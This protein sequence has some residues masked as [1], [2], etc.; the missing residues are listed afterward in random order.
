MDAAGVTA[1]TFAGGGAAGEGGLVLDW[2]GRQSFIGYQMC[3]II[4]QH[5]LVS[6]ACN[7][8]AR[9][10]VRQGYDILLEGFP[11]G[12]QS[13]KI[14]D[15]IRK[16]DRRFR[17]RQQMQEYI[18]FGRVFGIR[19]AIYVHDVPPDQ[20][21]EFYSNPYNPDSVTP[22]SYRGISQVDPYWM[23]PMLSG[24]GA[25]NAAGQHFYDPEWWN[26]QGRMYHRSHLCIYRPNEVADVLKPMYSYGGVSVAQSIYERVYAAERTANEAP[27]LAMT[28]RTTVW[29]TDLAEAF[30]N[31]ERFRTNLEIWTQFRDNYGVKIN[32]L[33]DTMQQ[34]ETSLADLDAVIMGQYQLVAAIARVPATK[35]L[36]TTPKGFNATGEYEE[37]S[38]HEELE[39]IQEND[40]TPLL[41][42]HYSRLLRSEIQ[43]RFAPAISPDVLEIG[44]DWAPLDSPTAAE[45]AAIEKTQA[46]TD[47][48]LISIG[49]IDPLEVRQ[50]IRLDR[51][52]SYQ[53]LTD[54]PEAGTPDAVIEEFL[55][56]S[57]AP[58]PT[59]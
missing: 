6:K 22:G 59:A 51:S 31:A 57:A 29:N 52:G 49:A 2:F 27:Q 50:R 39:T 20:A 14:V 26:I 45:Y 32:D 13:D 19:V 8:P 58:D 3:A 25:S 7:M 17:I 15:A 36:G 43:P 46:E 10:A 42:G 16:A 34:F 38:Y 5:W 47:Q 18:T 4:A 21:T 41:D 35:L 30:A 12:T 9:D 55:N 53:T 11:E 48:I 40:L 56:A 54:A 24:E 33:N 37:A 44:H 1:A 28:K 23:A